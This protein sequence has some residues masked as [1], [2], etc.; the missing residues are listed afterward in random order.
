MRT[1]VEV[2]ASSVNVDV[3]EAGEVLEHIRHHVELVAKYR[4]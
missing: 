4:I 3:D 2:I 1:E